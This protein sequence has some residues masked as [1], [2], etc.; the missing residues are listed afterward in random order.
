MENKYVISSIVELDVHLFEPLIKASEK[1]G[2]KFLTRLKNDWISGVNRFDKKNE[3]LYQIE[4]GKKI[5]AIGGINDN[6][7]N[8]NGKVG[9]IM[10]VYVLSKYRN[11]GIGRKLVLYLIEVSI[12]KYEK[13]T[14]RTDTEEASKFYE[15]IGFERIKS[16]ISSHQF[17]L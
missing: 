3:K 6:P 10:H 16:K 17:I 2:F 4:I 15:S 13:I 8:E 12:G 9:R 1:E 11:R 5:V 7:Y 14:L